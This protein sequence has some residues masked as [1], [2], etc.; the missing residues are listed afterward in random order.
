MNKLIV[1]C[2]LCFY[3]H[4][5]CSIKEYTILCISNFSEYNISFDVKE[6]IGIHKF[7]VFYDTVYRDKQVFVRLNRPHENIGRIYFS[8]ACIDKQL[9]TR[10]SYLKEDTIYMVVKSLDCK[11]IEF[12]HEKKIGVDSFQK[13]FCEIDNLSLETQDSIFESNDN[14]ISKRLFKKLASIIKTR[15]SIS[16]I[17][18]IGKNNS[19]FKLIRLELNQDN[20]KHDSIIRLIFNTIDTNYSNLIEY[21]NLTKR[22]S[23]SIRMYEV[24]DF[25]ESIELFDKSLKK[26]QLPISDSINTILAFWTKSCLNCYIQFDSLKNILDYS[27]K[28]AKIL[29]INIDNNYQ[30]WLEGVSHHKIT[31]FTY[32]DLK[33]SNSEIYNKFNI[34]TLPFYVL[35][36]KNRI[37]RLIESD[38]NKI[39]EKISKDF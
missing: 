17:F 24:G 3:N 2:L 13:F 23:K 39:L 7:D 37:I 14:V 38:Y 9:I 4:A 11:G 26:V 16:L 18:D 15:D 10:T 1:W 20:Y 32:S 5:F 6:N 25:F 12:S 27:D 33:G 30:R 35:V 36:D 29:A 34:K 28:T 22:L 8:L 31:W 21:K 19:Y